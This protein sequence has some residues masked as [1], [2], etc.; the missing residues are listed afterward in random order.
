MKNFT[1]VSMGKVRTTDS[2]WE[3]VFNPE[4]KDA[5]I[6]LDGFSYIQVLF[7][8]HLHDTPGDR[9]TISCKKPYTKGPEVL[10]IFATRSDYRP[11]PIGLSICP[12]KSIHQ[13][14]GIVEVYYIDAENESPVIDVKPYHPGIDRIREAGVPDW[15]QHWPQWYEDSGSFNWEAEFNFPVS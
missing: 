10:G 1:V 9:K 4:Y 14:K 6:G 12:V 7:W 15:C 5:L 11:N 2:T 8:L 3:L 13:K